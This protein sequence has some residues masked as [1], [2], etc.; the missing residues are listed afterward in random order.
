MVEYR[1]KHNKN[2][3][4]ALGP[5]VIPTLQLSSAPSINFELPSPVAPQARRP[6]FPSLDRS[7]Q[8]DPDALKPGVIRDLDSVEKAW[9]IGS[10]S[11]NPTPNPDAGQPALLTADNVKRSTEDFFDI[12]S[13][14]QITTRTIRSVRNYL[15]SLPDDN[16]SLN[17]S[18]SKYPVAS[19]RKHSQSRVKQ[20]ANSAPNSSSTGGG[21]PFPSLPP[22]R[23]T[24][25]RN[26]ALDVLAALRLLEES[27]RIPLSDDAYDGL[28]VGSGAGDVPISTSDEFIVSSR[29]SS[30][31][32]NRRNSLFSGD[33]D[34]FESTTSASPSN[35]ATRIAGSR[36]S[37]SLAVAVKGV[38]PLQ[39]PSGVIHVWS[40]GDDDDE[41]NEP[42]EEKRDHWDERLVLGG[43]WL[44]KHVPIGSLEKE[45]DVVA[46]YLDV[47]DEVHLPLPWLDVS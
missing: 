42:D 45:R 39:G 16:H 14:L 47:V 43:G 6:A 29:A 31:A 33:E 3:V 10:H 23:L 15:V 18:H 27:N 41:F 4:P 8:V 30:A 22:D 9:R 38:V 12:L 25:I 35:S 46:R 34:E 7:Y 13:V 21:A 24:R 2:L 28:S 17:S 36:A 5:S 20:T 44:Y 40:D 19:L 1:T 26:A 32:G 11:I 37:S